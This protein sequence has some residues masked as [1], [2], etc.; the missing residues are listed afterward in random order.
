MRVRRVGS[1]YCHTEGNR[2][3]LL[4]IISPFSPANT[5]KSAPT[6]LRPFAFPPASADAIREKCHE[7]IQP[8]R[9]CPCP[10]CL[11]GSEAELFAP[12]AIEVARDPQ[13]GVDASSCGRP[14]PRR[15]AHL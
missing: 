5:Q 10:Q 2:E 3:E 7:V 14:N 1:R 11:R 13:P 12:S 4:Q 9:R 6:E 15:P 8:L